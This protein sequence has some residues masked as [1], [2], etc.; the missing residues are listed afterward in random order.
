MAKFVRWPD[1]LIKRIR[2]SVY[3]PDLIDPEGRYP[4]TAKGIVMKCPFH[5]EKEPSFAVYDQ[6]FTCFSGV[7][8]E[9]GD[10]FDWL[11]KTQGMSFQD[12][13][14]H[15]APYAGVE[16][17]GEGESSDPKPKGPERALQ[18]AQ[19]LF[20]ENQATA[21][22][23]LES[24]G[25]HKET[26]QRYECGFAHANGCV[27]LL[28]KSFSKAELVEAGLFNVID[29]DRMAN[30]FRNRCM[31]PVYDN[32]T[33]VGFAGRVVAEAKPKYK[34]SPES[35]HFHKRS[36]LFGMKQALPAIRK[37]Q[38]IIVVEGYLDVLALSQAQVE[39]S[40]S[41]MGTALT[42][43]QFNAARK[44]AKEIVFCFDG[45]A[46]GQRAALLAAENCLAWL[47]EGDKVSFLTLPEGL[48]PDECLRSHGKPAWDFMF[49]RRE[50]L[51][52]FITRHLFNDDTPENVSSSH[53]KAQT[54]LK[55]IN[56]AP[57]F[58]E[59]LRK[60]WQS[61]TGVPLSD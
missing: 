54:Y 50:L 35:D 42:D 40:V 37:T 20:L 57:A 16:L 2:E 41:S 34:N 51:S 12:A 30:V 44:V 22:E 18:A 56:Y 31:F 21:L 13:V 38:S 52:N 58:R 26:A 59:A 7:C 14:R 60:R 15:L 49:E 47:H 45:D 3:L 32:V 43:E 10:A 6:R 48:D 27:P 36:L 4:R 46:A 5:D 23:Y 61:I 33:L 17:E 9:N 29:Q 24:R 25:I 19:S 1:S 8:G 53:L 55:K 28:E 39:N 11:K